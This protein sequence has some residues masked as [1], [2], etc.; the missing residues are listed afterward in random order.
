MDKTIL[1]KIN[2]NIQEQVST[3]S[4]LKYKQA[5]KIQFKKKDS[6]QKDERQSTNMYP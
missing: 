1:T 3:Q 4:Q 2:K 5:C 6:M